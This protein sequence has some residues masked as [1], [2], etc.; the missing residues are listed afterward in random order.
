MPSSGEGDFLLGE[1]FDFVPH[2]VNA[3]ETRSQHCARLL[4][5]TRYL[6]GNFPPT[7]VVVNPALVFEFPFREILTIYRTIY[8]SGALEFHHF[9]SLLK[10]FRRTKKNLLTT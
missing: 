5:P 2:N 6:R 8:F 10:V 1:H 9:Y 4:R 3:P 7:L